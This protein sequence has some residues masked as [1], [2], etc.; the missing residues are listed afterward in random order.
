MHHEDEV[1]IDQRCD[2]HEI[3]HELIGFVDVQ[4]FVNSLRTGNHQQ[5]VAIRQRL[6][7]RVGPDGGAG[8]WPVFHNEGL[9]QG[10]AQLFGDGARIDVRRSPCAERDN[11]LHGA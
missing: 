3:T 2:R 11:D 1:G 4:S 6:D 8:A 5:R 9:M 7:D 10:F